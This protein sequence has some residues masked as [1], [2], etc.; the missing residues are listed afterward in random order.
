MLNELKPIESES[1]PAPRGR[2]LRITLLVVIA[3]VAGLVISSI[4]IASL[5][6]T[7]Y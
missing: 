1:A 5:G 6:A 4:A 3:S 2:I 7:G